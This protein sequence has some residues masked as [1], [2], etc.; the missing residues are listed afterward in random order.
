MRVRGVLFVCLLALL[1]WLLSATLARKL[2]SWGWTG[3]P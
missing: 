2:R 1:L 3:D